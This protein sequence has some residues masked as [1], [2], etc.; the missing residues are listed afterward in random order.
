MGRFRNPFA[1]V[2]GNMDLVSGGLCALL[3]KKKKKKEN[4][5]AAS[6]SVSVNQVS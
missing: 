6:M 4:V 1:H 3:E 5:P 2:S